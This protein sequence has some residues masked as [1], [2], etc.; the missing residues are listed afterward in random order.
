M[1]NIGQKIKELR[2][3]KMMTQQELA[4][5]QITRNMLSRIENGCA[6]PSLPTLLYIAERLGVPAGYLLV[7]GDEEFRYKKAGKMPDIMRAYCAG[8]WDICADLCRSL[9]SVDDEL[10]YLMYVCLFNSAKDAFNVGDFRKSLELFDS[11]RACA[12]MTVY[13]VNIMNEE[14]EAYI[15][16]ISCISPSLTANIE[17]VSALP[18]SALSDPFCR[19]FSIVYAIDAGNAPALDPVNYTSDADED[20][21]LFTEHI[22]A[23]LKMRSG[24]YNEAYHILRRVLSADE[25]IPAPILYFIFSDLEVCCRSLSD[26]KGAYEYSNDK[27]GMLERFL[28]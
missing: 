2:S 4:G 7:S 20:N 5:D 21:R 27:T 19:Y 26:Y 22:T 8:D 24:Q 13:P 25:K 28:G 17:T 1:T 16:C 14:V 15:F 10:G 12:S 23:K 3:A 6:L 18:Y 11:A 9:G